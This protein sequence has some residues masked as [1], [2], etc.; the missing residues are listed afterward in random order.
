MDMD[1]DADK[2]STW[3]Q[4]KQRWKMLDTVVSYVDSGDSLK[5]CAAPL[6]ELVS[7]AN[8]SI[9]EPSLYQQEME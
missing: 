3:G 5:T 6:E 9:V 4:R 7:K 8:C 1:G 2:G